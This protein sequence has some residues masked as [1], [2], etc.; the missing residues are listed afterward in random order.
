MEHGWFLFHLVW[1]GFFRLEEFL[2]SELTRNW[3]IPVKP[4][5]QRTKSSGGTEELGLG[6]VLGK[7][8]IGE[9]HFHKG[10]GPGNLGPWWLGQVISWFHFRGTS[11]EFLLPRDSSHFGNLPKRG[12]PRVWN[13]VKALNFLATGEKTEQ[14][15][16]QPNF[17]KKNLWVWEHLG[18]LPEI[19][20]PGF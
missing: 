7:F 2:G 11:W 17:P 12:Q 15:Q 1:P 16:F 3:E 4:F 13:P 8:G 14:R 10:F 20:N 5:G 9:N 6:K 19:S 18:L